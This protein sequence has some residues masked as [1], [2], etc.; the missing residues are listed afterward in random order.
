MQAGEDEEEE[1]DE[2]MDAYSQHGTV[3]RSIN[4]ADADARGAAASP[5][6]PLALSA[7]LG[8]DPSDLVALR[9]SFFPQS[10]ALDPLPHCRSAPRDLSCGHLCL[11]HLSYF[12]N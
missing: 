8:L 2:D 11:E 4:A 9:S 1:E 6:L 10:S 5:V 12:F 3:L 7:Q